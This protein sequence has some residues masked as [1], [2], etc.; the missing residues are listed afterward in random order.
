MLV[1]PQATGDGAQP[2][3]HL[4]GE[5][6]CFRFGFG[7]R[8]LDLRVLCVVR[9]VWID[10]EEASASV[11]ARPKMQRFFAGGAMGCYLLVL[12]SSMPNNHD[13]TL[14][15]MLLDNECTL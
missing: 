8:G 2:L 7:Q 11:E 9:T 12:S 15:S 5:P 13:C 14:Q 3:P 4:G 1:L 6:Q 10:A